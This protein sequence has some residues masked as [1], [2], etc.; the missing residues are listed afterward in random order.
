MA[1]ERKYS[2]EVRDAAVRRV[3]E[4]RQ[5]EPGNRSIL[6][7]VAEEFEVGEQSL[8]IWVKRLDD[9]MFSAGK[10]AALRQAP[11]ERLLARIAELEAELAGAHERIAVMGE[12]IEVLKKAS[13][14]FAAEL[15][16]R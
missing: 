14:I 10:V 6:R 5:A 8:R 3:V 1:F 12:E 9:G 2:D 4:R 16:K 15:A 7:E 11:R 13:A